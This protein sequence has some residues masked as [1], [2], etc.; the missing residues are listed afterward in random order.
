MSSIF[1]E[2]FD[3]MFEQLDKLNEAAQPLRDEVEKNRKN[4]DKS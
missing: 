3:K 1:G 4:E 2:E